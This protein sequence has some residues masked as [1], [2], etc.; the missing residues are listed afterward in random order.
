MPKTASKYNLTWKHGIQKASLLLAHM[1]TKWEAGNGTIGLLKDI[2]SPLEILR[3]P[4][5]THQNSCAWYWSTNHFT[6]STMLTN[7][8]SCN[9]PFKSLYSLKKHRRD[10][11][12]DDSTLIPVFKVASGNNHFSSTTQ[13]EVGPKWPDGLQIM[14][15]R[16]GWKNQPYASSSFP[17]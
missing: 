6:M 7:C 4:F 5:F 13:K 3:L 9:K 17:R 2:L 15:G 10:R 14:V 12:H 11:H 8:S 1:F 16:F